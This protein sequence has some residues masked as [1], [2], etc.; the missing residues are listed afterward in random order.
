[1]GSRS[2]CYACVTPEFR[3]GLGTQQLL[4]PVSQVCV[5]LTVVS[6]DILPTVKK[7]ICKV[8]SAMKTRIRRHTPAYVRDQAT[9]SGMVSNAALQCIHIRPVIR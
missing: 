5:F 3:T 7:C 2:L 8:T 9:K 4:V 6:S 1:M